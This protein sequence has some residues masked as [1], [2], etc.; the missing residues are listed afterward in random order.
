MGVHM[1]IHRYYIHVYIYIYMIAHIIDLIAIMIYHCMKFNT[2]VCHNNNDN[3]IIIL[4]QTH[5]VNAIIGNE[6][7]CR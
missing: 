6:F 7:N 1:N 4:G 5:Y 2:A 3:Y